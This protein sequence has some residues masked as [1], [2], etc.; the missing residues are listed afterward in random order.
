MPSSFMELNWLAKSDKDIL[1]P[2]VI[3]SSEYPYGGYYLSPVKREC[4]IDDRYYPQDRGIIVINDDYFSD[5]IESVLA[6]E[7]RHLWQT[8]QGWP[9][10][11]SQWNLDDSVPYRKKIIRY[12]TED[13]AEMDALLFEIKKAPC[14]TALEWY[15]WILKDSKA[16]CKRA[17]GR[18]G[19]DEGYIK[20]EG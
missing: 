9:L 17:R 2:P 16:M 1:L 4:L 18:H 12:F 3:L 5:C 19:V 13:Y 20:R 7:W 14:D 15:E 10:Y 6:H 11:D 8:H